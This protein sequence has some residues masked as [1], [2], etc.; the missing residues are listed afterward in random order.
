MGMGAIMKIRS[1][2]AVIVLWIGALCFS[3]PAL[4][5]MTDVDGDGMDDGWETAV[6]LN[7]DVRDA[8]GDPDGDGLTNLEE[9]LSGTD[10]FAV[11]SDGDGLSDWNEIHRYGTNPAM[12]DTDGGGRPDG[13]EV[14][15]GGNPLNPDDDAESQSVS[16]SLQAGWNMFSVPLRPASGD[17]ASVLD[18]IKGAYTAIWAYS[19]G[20]WQCYDPANPGLSDLE[21][22]E[23]GRGYWINMKTTG[24]LTVSGTP[25]S[26]PLSIYEGWNLVGYNA[27]HPQSVETAL[28]S[29]DGVCKSVWSFRLGSWRLYDPENPLYS[30]LS[31]F[32]PGEGYW[33][34]AER[35]AEWRLP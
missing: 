28:S 27:S 4:G 7:P 3:G 8:S 20:K 16:I 15:G 32:S 6:G 10:P 34:E 31:E 24:R 19:R 25:V 35:D 5:G 2:V 33:I 11:D 30:D 18:A 13:Q 17:V 22:I 23:P 9:Y 21:R 1:A 29:L 26:A 14:A 12:A